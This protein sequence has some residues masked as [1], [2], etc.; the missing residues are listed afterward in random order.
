MENMHSLQKRIV[1]YQVIRELKNNSVMLLSQISNLVSFIVT[2]FSH[3]LDLSMK[4]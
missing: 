2:Y 4:G 3:V 1:N